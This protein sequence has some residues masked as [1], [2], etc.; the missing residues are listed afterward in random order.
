MPNHIA[1]LHARYRVYGAHAT[2][3][4]TG[5]RLDRVM[6][7]SLAPAYAAALEQ[8]LG[9]DPTVYVVRD[10]SAALSLRLTQDAPDGRIAQR[11]GA[12]LAQ[13]TLATIA[14][15][16]GEP[17]RG[18]VLRF[19]DQ[20]EYVARCIGDLLDGMAPDIWFY[21][22]LVQGRHGHL[23]D[24]L[25]IILLEQREH[26]PMILAQL[27]HS[28]HIEPLLR[29][30]DVPS[31]RQL[32]SDLRANARLD[33]AACQPLFAAAV[34]LGSRL[35]LWPTAPAADAL[36]A[37]LATQPGPADWRDPV[38]LARAVFAILR[39]LAGPHLR[40]AG[41]Q[42]AGP[43]LLGLA[44]TD[45]PTQ[46]EAPG[47]AQAAPTDTAS[48]PEAPT[49]ASHPGPPLASRVE[50]AV[51][52]LDWLDTARLR[53]DV[54]A[55]LT[56]DAFEPSVPNPTLPVR[57]HRGTPTPRQRRLLEHLLAVLG[58]R[59]LRLDASLPDSP[60]NALRW[61][62]ALVEAY[63]AWAGDALAADV[64][65]RLLAV[66]AVVRD[67]VA[68]RD[69]VAPDADQPSAVAVTWSRVEA[70]GE[71]GLTVLAALAGMDLADVPGAAAAT[72]ARRGRAASG[73]GAAS[74]T[75]GVD[76]STDTDTPANHP[77]APSEAQSPAVL[78][79]HLTTATDRPTAPFAT[80]PQEPAKA[81]QA[82]AADPLAALVKAFPHLSA[83]TSIDTANAGVA[84]IVRT[85]LDT[86]LVSLANDL[87]YPSGE[88]E[89][90][91]SLLLA[92][93]LRWAGPAA[94]LDGRIDPGLLCLA[95]DSPSAA[96][97]PSLDALRERLAATRAGRHAALQAAWTRSLMGQRL[98]SP[99][100]LRLYHLADADSRR[101][102]VAG[103]ASAVVWP[104]GRALDAGESVADLLAEWR[105]VWVTAT[106]RPPD[107][108]LVDDSLAAEL[109]GETG[110]ELASAAD[111]EERDLHLAGRQQLLAAHASLEAGRLGLPDLDL[112][113][114]L[115]AASLLRLWARWLHRFSDSTIPYLL[116]N[117]LHRPGR[118]DIDTDTLD[119]VMNPG[120]FDTIIEMAGYLA[121][122][123]R[124]A[125]LDQRRIR[126]YLRG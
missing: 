126:F 79:T 2:A 55:W 125:W 21:A 5:A 124:V 33:E 7:E 56:A 121:P 97:L 18:V 34:E 53:H 66:W 88:D 75:A 102:I 107:R 23:S 69:R 28:R 106:G 60:A 101:L 43:W 63:P 89:A 48:P 81:N 24:T 19:A 72:V 30:L 115:L 6:R 65:Q 52:P 44:A 104:L 117:F 59:Q 85:L 83:V 45:D 15:W 42:G 114:G 8:A 96:S 91:T 98:L 3:S 20:A 86:R 49:L 103:D 92:L 41:Q 50:A 80:H 119:V 36:A 51:R 67:A 29:A 16:E 1:R 111:V 110:I 74:A 90:A 123:D 108:I 105:A 68:L 4:A 11:W 109:R 61:Y 78:T 122:T 57:P 31:Q 77:A 27:R 37:Y 12:S 76:T 17:G 62:A 54:L 58:A 87:G 94:T 93:Y 120:P 82:P 38:D 64:I 100:I 116:H 10:V 95:G 46:A 14:R 22:P 73:S 112:T 32:W 47:P 70:L 99:S 9:D 35:D 25:R 113:V 13:A 26:L 39:F 84:L 71:P 40:R 118:I